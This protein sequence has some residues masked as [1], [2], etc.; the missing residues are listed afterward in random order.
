MHETVCHFEEQIFELRLALVICELGERHTE[1]RRIGA[2]VKHGVAVLQRDE[3][4]ATPARTPK[5]R[6]QENQVKPRTS[7]RRSCWSVTHNPPIILLIL[8]KQIDK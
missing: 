8:N 2:K 1:V 4:A 5:S 7:K 3:R 6:T